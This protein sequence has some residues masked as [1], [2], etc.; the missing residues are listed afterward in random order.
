MLLDLISG[1]LAGIISRTCVA[2]LELWKLQSQ[3]SYLPNASIKQVL[4]KEGVRYLWKG[5]FTNCIRVAPQIAVNFSV[6]E[7]SKKH[8]HTNNKGLLLFILIFLDCHSSTCIF[9]KY[10]ILLN[11]PHIL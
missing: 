9:F 4:K 10:M 1:G 5:N 6:F 2:P 11:P 7:A 3:A 8:I